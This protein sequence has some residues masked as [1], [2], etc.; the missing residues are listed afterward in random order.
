MLVVTELVV[1]GTQCT[2]SNG[3]SEVEILGK[4]KLIK[5]NDDVCDWGKLFF[6]P[7]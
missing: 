1:S 6:H 5:K 2:R 4:I 7:D 3:Q